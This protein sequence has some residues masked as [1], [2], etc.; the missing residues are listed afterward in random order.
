MPVTIR[1][2]R[3]VL[4]FYTFLLA[5]AMFI[6][7]VLIGVYDLQKAWQNADRDLTYALEM[8]S[9][10]LQRW[11]TINQNTVRSLAALP[12]V[13]RKSFESMF[14]DFRN[15][16]RANSNFDSIVFVDAKG[17][18]VVQS[19]SG[20]NTHPDLNISDRDYFK[21]AIEGKSHITDVIIGRTSGKPI[22]IFSIP[23]IE[24][25]GFQGLVFGS[26]RFDTLLNT[27]LSTHFGATGKFLLLN[28]QGKSMQETGVGG[29]SF[30]DETIAALRSSNGQ[31]VSYREA[32]GSKYLAKGKQLERTNFFLVARMDYGEYL[33]P[34]IA[35]MLYFVTVSVVLLFFMLSISRKLYKK[36]DRSLN[37]L[38]EGVVKTEQGEY[39]SLDPDL[40]E[41]APFELREL[42]IAF[43]SMAETVR[44]KTAEL[45]FRSFH[46]EL[47]GLYNRAYFE[48]AMRR[49]DSG[50]FNP[51]TVVV[52][53]VNGLKMIN[54]T[55]GHKAG[56]DLIVAAA[57]ALANAGRKTD[58]VARIGGD[59]FAMLL[60]ES[61]DETAGEVLR[62]IRSEIDEYKRGEDS[63]PLNIA[64]GA[65]TT[66]GRIQNIEAL[67]SEADKQMYASKQLEKPHSKR[68]VLAFLSSRMH[69]LRKASHD[70]KRHMAA[71]AAI[72]E[73]FVREQPDIAPEKKEFL[74]LLAKNHDIGF[75]EIPPEI[76]EKPGPLTDEE[77]LL[78]QRHP[79]TGAR[80]AS[81][82][83][84]LADLAEP[85]RLHHRWWNGKGYPAGDGG[86]AI[87]LES[88]LMAI[89]DAYE[90]MT[91]DKI[92]RT[93]LSPEEAL[94]ELHR[95]AG[96]QFD[97]VWTERFITFFLEY[98]ER[99]HIFA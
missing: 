58:I 45:E 67:F 62:R 64:C 72:M 60:P 21:D 39:D 68:E 84:E 69:D 1:S 20:I 86:E 77:Y 7:P 46:D 93:P 16:S 99:E 6:F 27:I 51:V 79:E 8:Q 74:I 94:K 59:E 89:V 12:T 25:D 14:E 26:I 33:G 47:T 71:C 19:G 34:F 5:A 78:V 28:A 3:G 75:T 55:L 57:N 83:P 40:L 10:A 24:D 29:N 32:S 31:S 92:Y 88:R 70:R 42:G 4:N 50:R 2:I 73:A 95:C 30:S 38:F 85:I 49:F 17:S 44:S 81:L 61:T 97:P 36:V 41:D 54:D 80:I 56:D 53:D 96:S 91:G 63:L 52:C 48:D 76:T 11:F 43:S 82:F 18:P 66:S 23:L 15:F 37:L 22:V 35:N 87:P 13:Q 98:R 65:A 9:T 90:A